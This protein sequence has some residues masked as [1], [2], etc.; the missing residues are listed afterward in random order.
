MKYKPGEYIVGDTAKRKSGR[1]RF[2]KWYHRHK[3]EWPVKKERK[4]GGGRRG[5]WCVKAITRT[6]GA[7]SPH[8]IFI[9]ACPLSDSLLERLTGSKLLRQTP[10]RTFKEEII[11]GSEGVSKAKAKSFAK[12]FR[13][14]LLPK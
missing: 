11:L 4:P 3:V 14:L 12:G 1:E 9:A 2:N 13:K 6:T 7:Y 10:K 8:I 5:G